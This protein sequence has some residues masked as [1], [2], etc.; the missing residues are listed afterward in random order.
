M[1]RRNMQRF[2]EKLNQQEVEKST[3]N[4]Q[5][6][7]NVSEISHEETKK[8]SNSDPNQINVSS[9]SFMKK[10][11]SLPEPS[12]NISNSSTCINSLQIKDTNDNVENC[13]LDTLKLISANTN[14]SADTLAAIKDKGVFENMQIIKQKETDPLEL[15]GK[16]KFSF[17]EYERNPASSNKKKHFNT[18]VH[19]TYMNLR[20]NTIGIFLNEKQESLKYQST[21][22]L[23]LTEE[24]KS[25]LM[26][27]IKSYGRQSGIITKKKNGVNMG[28]F[29]YDIIYTLMR[30]IR[31]IS[32]N[33]SG[34]NL[35]YDEQKIINF[36]VLSICHPNLKVRISVIDLLN[37][38]CSL[39]GGHSRVL[40]A[41]DNMKEVLHETAS[42]EYFLSSFSRDSSM[43][44]DYT[45]SCVQFMS[46]LINR[47]QLL[48]LRLYLQIQFESLDIYEILETC[49]LHHDS[50]A[51]L[52]AQID[53]FLDNF[54]NIS[55][56]IDDAEQKPLLLNEI[57][58]LEEDF[59]F[60]EDTHKRLL[61]K[62]TEEVADFELKYKTIS[63]VNE[64]LNKSLHDEKEKIMKISKDLDDVLKEKL[65]ISCQLKD[66]ANQ[67]ELLKR[68]A[69]LT[70]LSDKKT[71]VNAPS[72]GAPPSIG[73]PPA[74]GAP[75][76]T[77][78]PPCIGAPPPIG[79]PPC[80][81]APPP[82]GGPPCIGGP[83]SIGGPP[84]IGVP[85]GV[86]G[87]PGIAK[88][89]MSKASIP[90]P[91]IYQKYI[92]G[93]EKLIGVHWAPLKHNDINGTFFADVDEESILKKLDLK[94]LVEK[95]ATKAAVPLK[96]KNEKKDDSSKEASKKSKFVCL[97]SQNRVKTIAVSRRRIPNDLLNKLDKSINDFDCETL[98]VSKIEVL[99]RV[100][101]DA[102]EIKIYKQYKS[103]N[104]PIS[105]LSPDDQFL[106]KLVDINRIETKLKIMESMCTYNETKEE[107]EKTI[108]T[109]VL[110]STSVKNCKKFFKVMEM[111]LTIGN[112]MNISKRGAAKGFKLQSLD[113]I[114]SVKSQKDQKFTIL[115]YL[116]LQINNKFNDLDGFSDDLM[117]FMSKGAHVNFDTINTN[118]NELD[119]IVKLADRELKNRSESKPGNL[120][121]FLTKIRQDYEV[122][123][124]GF[125]QAK[126]QY[127]ETVEYFGENPSIC[128][129][130]VFFNIIDR[131]IN[132][133]VKTR[134]EMKEAEKRLLQ[135]EERKKKLEVEKQKKQKINLI[136]KDKI[137]DGTVDQLLNFIAKDRLKAKSNN[138]N[139]NRRKGQL[140]QF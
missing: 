79:G 83:P 123:S 10:H 124:D 128:P 9:M 40:M 5:S 96:S 37:V 73:G 61:H 82:I 136:D 87:P 29:I 16:L 34:F 102:A 62:H 38:I 122:F 132:N 117:P 137:T 105:V 6:T 90:K 107:I 28:D 104:K 45:I 115:Q 64:S 116:V 35:I 54:I 20:T 66:K 55:T 135:A 80:I 17:S 99:L 52:N 42:F 119:K 44:L 26:K 134:Q 1:S 36:V 60:L 92:V 114:M 120:V 94:C 106:I 13:D 8:C 23:Q 103:D 140:T 32:N 125:K 126:S 47:C 77:G 100:V 48:N 91:S 71:N 22:S 50:N 81:G 138:N 108:N 59:S 89:L 121:T 69:K 101:P 53:E 67:V 133:F 74:I 27:N 12:M 51:N 68:E 19:Q 3:T 41:F 24:R 118:L 97:I 113:N 110:A 109:L 98:S 88:P 63:N 30:S 43:N 131:F 72:V 70:I 14:V 46:Q 85:P 84:G 4:S 57:H 25:S 49:R 111:F 18:Y 58:K 56:V 75:P 112:Y 11:L 93:D 39:I 7:D 129:P 95:F 76:P 33:R 2:Y 21:L 65:N 130:S 86:R 15:I 127:K 31:A 139:N 78:G